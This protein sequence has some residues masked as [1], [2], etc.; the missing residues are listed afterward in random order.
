MF[1]NLNYIFYFI[2]Q[3]S[4]LNLLHLDIIGKH[5]PKI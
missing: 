4:R 1:D 5:L 3:V 2:F